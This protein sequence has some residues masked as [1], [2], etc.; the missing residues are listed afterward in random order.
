MQKAIVDD[1]SFEYYRKGT[2]ILDNNSIVIAGGGVYPGLAQEFIMKNKHAVALRD[3]YMSIVTRRSII[4]IID[5]A[6]EELYRH[7]IKQ[8]RLRMNDNSLYLIIGKWHVIRS[9]QQTS[10][11]YYY[12]RIEKPGQIAKL[13]PNDNL[14]D[15]NK[16]H[17]DFRMYVTE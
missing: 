12:S 6:N 13:K 16:L 3:P 10:T 7:F 9:E 8:G 2:L 5:F 1:R 15:Q 4:Y 17:K 14:E 11:K